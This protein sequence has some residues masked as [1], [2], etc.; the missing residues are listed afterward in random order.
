M[1]DGVAEA[2]LIAQGDSDEGLR[3]IHDALRKIAEAAAEL[4]QSCAEG[5]TTLLGTAGTP[6]GEGS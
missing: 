5:Q 3:A 2:G 6:G 1:V 4:A